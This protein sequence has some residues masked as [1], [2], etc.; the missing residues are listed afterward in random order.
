MNRTT[1]ISTCAM[2]VVG[3]AWAQTFDLGWHTVDSGGV[4][5]STDGQPNGLTN[6]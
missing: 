3:T 5:N 1:V 2:L 4:M 6:R